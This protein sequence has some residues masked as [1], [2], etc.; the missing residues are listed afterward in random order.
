MRPSAPE[1]L[2]WIAAFSGAHAEALLAQTP[3]RIDA[4]QGLVEPVLAEVLGKYLGTGRV[5]AAQ[6]AGA[7]AVFHYVFIGRYDPAINQRA[8]E[9]VAVLRAQFDAVIADRRA[10]LARGQGRRDDV[11]GRMLR[12]GRPGLTLNDV[13]L[14]NTLIGIVVAW[15]PN[16]IRAAPMA[17]DELLRRP[18]ALRQAREAALKGDERRVGDLR[19]RGAAPPHA[20]PVA[21]AP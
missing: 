2:P 1:D 16:V 17:I 18:D 11:L 6:L 15:V 20:H 4:V 5:S 7:R 8:A 13:E 10:A 14:R 19:A 3:G 9:A 12:D 21:R